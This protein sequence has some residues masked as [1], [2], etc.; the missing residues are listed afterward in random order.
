MMTVLPETPPIPVWGGIPMRALESD[1][2]YA[3][4][5]ADVGAVRIDIVRKDMKDGIT[6]DELQRIKSDCG[7][8]EQDAVE[9]YPS[10][11]DIFNTGNVRHLFVFHEKLP[12][13]RRTQS[14]PTSA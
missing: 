11:E 10:D 13:I 9:F 8:G 4:V 2:F 12:L 3:V 6:W 7:Y 1:N 14:W 5:V